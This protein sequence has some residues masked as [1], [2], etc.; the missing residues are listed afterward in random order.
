VVLIG[1]SQRKRDLC[2]IQPIK[3]PH[4]TTTEPRKR[5]RR[6]SNTPHTGGGSFVWCCSSTYHRGPRT[7]TRSSKAQKLTVAETHSPRFTCW[8]RIRLTYPTNIRTESHPP[9]HT[10]HARPSREDY[11]YCLFFCVFTASLLQSLPPCT[12]RSMS[13]RASVGRA[14]RAWRGLLLVRS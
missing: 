4:H 1:R 7:R 8:L 2:P 5:T 10:P 14:S 3:S 13:V 9:S 11:F 12:P 6:I